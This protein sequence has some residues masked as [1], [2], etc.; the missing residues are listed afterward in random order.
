MQLFLADG[1]KEALLEE[2]R[3]F[4][5]LVDKHCMFSYQTASFHDK[6][7]I[8]EKI[9]SRSAQQ[10]RRLYIPQPR[11]GG[12]IWSVTMVTGKNFCAD[13]TRFSLYCLFPAGTGQR[14]SD[15]EA[16][17]LAGPVH[18]RHR[19]ARQRADDDRGAA[20]HRPH[21]APTLPLPVT[22]QRGTRRTV[23]G[24]LFRTGSSDQRSFSSLV[25]SG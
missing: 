18:R 19:N 16:E 20:H 9:G 4:C 21:R 14:H 15:G 3:R 8:A 24:P 6:V 7:E 11:G 5:F 23:P 13:L 2:K 1:C 22:P 10:Q 17:Q 12:E 25:W